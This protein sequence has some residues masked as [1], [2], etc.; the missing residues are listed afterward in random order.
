MRRTTV[1]AAAPSPGRVELPLNTYLKVWV[2]TLRGSARAVAGKLIELGYVKSIS[3]LQPSRL[4][5]QGLV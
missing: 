1:E 4:V 5:A 2:M 3:S